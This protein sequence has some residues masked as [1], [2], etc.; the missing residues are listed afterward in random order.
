V[1]FSTTSNLRRPTQH[2]GLRPASVYTPWWISSIAWQR[3]QGLARREAP[4]RL[5]WLPVALAAGIGGYFALPVEPPVWVGPAGALAAIG[6][7]LLLR[8]WPVPGWIA[9]LVVAMC[10][11]FSAAELRTRTVATVM[12][13][14]DLW[15]EMDGRIVAIERRPSDWRLTLSEIH[16]VGRGVGDRTP[17]GARVA[18]SMRLVLSSASTIGIGDRIRMRAR[19]RPPSAPVAPGAFDFQRDA[20]FRGIGA[21]GFAVGPV[22][23]LGRGSARW[24]GRAWEAVDGIRDA[25]TRRIRAGL[26]DPAGS[27]AAA[28]LVGDRAGIDEPTA[29]AFR[30]TGLAH[31]L[32]ISGLHMGLVAGTVFAVVRVAL[33]ACPAIALGRPIKKWAAV[34]AFAAAGLY[35]LLAGAP[36]PTQRAFLMTGLVLG[37]V[38]LDREAISLH[39]VAWAAAAVLL[40]APES[41]TGPSFQLS[42]AAVT[43]LVA[44]WEVKSGRPGFRRSRR[45]GAVRWVLLYLLGVVATSVVASLVTSP[46][47]THHFQQVPVM[48][49]VANVVAVPVT[50]FV[51]MPAGV[52]SLVA[53]PFGLE[54][55]PLTLMGW[56]IDATLWAANAASDGPLTAIGVAAL[57]TGPLAVLALGGLWLAIWRTAIRWLG[58]AI[59]GGAGIWSV[60]DRPPDALISADGKLSAVHVEG[61]GWL[62]SQERGS[63]FVRDAWRRWWGGSPEASFRQAD[64]A[65]PSERFACDGLGCVVQ[66]NGMILAVPASP[67]AAIEDCGYADLI[68]T[69]VHFRRSCPGSVIVIDRSDLRRNGAHAVW[70]SAN[71]AR[72]RSVGAD[73]GDRPWVTAH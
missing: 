37:A 70:L 58:V 62:V 54:A 59:V 23:V 42:F 30:Q 16:L 40:M 48:G 73:R 46:I 28:M 26:S 22:S 11:G 68:V 20:F 21:V 66:V 39:M 6:I 65:E 50:A 29:A 67:E 15:A 51:T 25:V 71:G 7:A 3:V 52:A 69:G 63:G 2:G 27:I 14:R 53:M 18:V 57:G 9:L 47:V 12:L 17:S 72:I 64:Q 36:V 13:H 43:A 31:L 34:A 41:L 19:L 35:L 44:V 4:R 56:G 45:F 10:I 61:Q 33:A 60:L 38:L 24:D 1:V 49:A 5:L 8:R 32:A 55:G